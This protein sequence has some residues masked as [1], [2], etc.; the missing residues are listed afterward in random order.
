MTP[1]SS[2]LRIEY[3]PGQTGGA[4]SPTSGVDADR[5]LRPFVTAA[6]YTDHAHGKA[7]TATLTLSDADGRFTGR[8][9]DG[10]G[11]VAVAGG[12][13][14]RG[15]VPYWPVL[16]G[17]RFRLALVLTNWYAPGEPYLLPWGT[18]EADSVRASGGAATSLTLELQSAELLGSA[19]GFRKTK[20]SQSWPPGTELFEVAGE[21]A[22]RHGLGLSFLAPTPAYPK[23][24][25][26]REVSD[27]GFLRA[28][29]GRAGL[30]MRVR[31][32]TTDGGV[33]LVVADEAGLSG[34]VPF[35]V[36]PPDLSAWSFDE[37]LHGRYKAA[38]CSYFDPRKNEV[39]EAT[40]KA[41]D[42]KDSAETLRIEATVG[43]EAEA[44]RIAEAALRRENRAGHS[45]RLTFAQGAPGVAAGSVVE[46]SGF[47]RY[48]G[49]YLADAVTHRWDAD[50]GFT[51]EANV[52]K[53]P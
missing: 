13:G 9:V 17:D 5:D 32:S 22:D 29:C 41:P 23:G 20:R 53:L 16:R 12:E 48:D 19:A 42:F 33:R 24:L 49:R 1:R 8:D 18:F 4:A 25:E 50:G 43:S 21:I 52:V 15:E 2:D 44:R 51:T 6:T 26:Q 3:L 45:G 36:L 39:V 46:P 31:E 37:A 28:L 47:G 10:L 27:A 7:D 11:L 35:E 34:Q 40:A 14:A 38:T 30:L